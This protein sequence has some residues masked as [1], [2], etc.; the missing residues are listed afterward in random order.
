VTHQALQPLAFDREA[1]CGPGDGPVGTLARQLLQTVAETPSAHLPALVG[2]LAQVQAVALSRLTTPRPEEHR[3]EAR[4]AN[5]SVREAARRLGVSSSYIYKN[6]ESLPFAVRIGRRLL[7]SERRLE[8]WN[9][10]R[11]GS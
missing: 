6:A 3:P 4:D 2:A 5:I 7:C 1:V 8:K 9:R 11:L 10:A